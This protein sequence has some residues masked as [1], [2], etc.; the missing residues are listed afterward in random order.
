MIENF[1]EMLSPSVVD[2][3]GIIAKPKKLRGKI[4]L[5]EDGVDNQRL[6]SF[7]LRKAGATVT[8]VDNGQTGV[9]K[10]LSDDYDLVL[11]DMQLPV[12]DGNAATKLLRQQGYKRPIIALTAHAM[13]QDIEKC[14]QAGCNDYLTKPLDRQS[15]FEKIGDVLSPEKN[16]PNIPTPSNSPA[17]EQSATVIV[18]LKQVLERFDGELEFFIDFAGTALSESSKQLEHLQAGL[19]VRDKEGVSA[20]LHCLVSSLGNMGAT[21]AYCVVQRMSNFIQ[22]GDFDGAATRIDELENE[23]LRVQTMISDL[24]DKAFT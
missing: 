23:I 19:S 7:L 24:A 15:F 21:A 12:M 20:A 1:A 3:K 6:I 22:Q 11:M 9:E 10:A 16:G 5:V 4:L 2:P 18:D 8:I 14:F 13:K 17:Q